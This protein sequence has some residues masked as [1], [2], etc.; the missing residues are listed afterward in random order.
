MMTNASWSNTVAAVKLHDRTLGREVQA[1][2]DELLE[3]LQDLLQYVNTHGMGGV[4]AQS[5][6]NSAEHAS[7]VIKK[8]GS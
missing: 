3:E 4:R 7:A 1:H 5:A 2:H 6:F 8:A